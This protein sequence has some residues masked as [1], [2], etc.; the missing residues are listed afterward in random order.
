[1]KIFLT[2]FSV[3]LVGCTALPKYT[4]QSQTGNDP[5]FIFGDRFGG[6]AVHGPGRIFAINV[7]DAI[8][9]KCAD[10]ALVGSTSNNWTKLNPPTVE[11]KTPAGKV[12]AIRGTF[13][14]GGTTCEP[15]TLSFV[16]KDAAIYSVD[17]KTTYN[18]CT[19][20]IVQ[21]LADSQ[22]RA[23]EGLNVLTGCKDK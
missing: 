10:F 18:K 15:P 4:Y 20:S 14:Y 19:L 11:I 2:L 8:S 3:L 22:Q 17:V 23:V 9:N 12:V 16:P 7:K 6:D 1:M 21:K 13:M 5:T